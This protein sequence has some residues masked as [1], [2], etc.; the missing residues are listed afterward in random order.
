LISDIE[1]D[2]PLYSMFPAG[3]AVLHRA[4]YRKIRLRAAAV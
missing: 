4:I 2:W 3:R 1:D